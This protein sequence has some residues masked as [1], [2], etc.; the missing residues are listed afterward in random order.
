MHDEDQYVEDEN[1]IKFFYKT[2]QHKNKFFIAADMLVGLMVLIGALVLFAQI[3]NFVGFLLPLYFLTFATGIIWFAVY[4]PAWL[5]AYCPFY[6]TF[7]G[8]GITFFLLGSVLLVFEHG[9]AVATSVISIIVA[10]VYFIFAALNKWFVAYNLGCDSL[11]SPIIPRSETDDDLEMDRHGEHKAVGH[12]PANSSSDSSV[13]GTDRTEAQ[14]AL[15][16][17][18]HLHGDSVISM[19]TA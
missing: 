10:C 6:F 17:E 3:H 5:H 2:C 4:T 1:D 8:R 19:P 12:K 9:M 15:N 18:S 13:Y 11:P 16:N 14:R 7:L